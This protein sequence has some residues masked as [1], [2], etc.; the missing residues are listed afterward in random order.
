MLPTTTTLSFSAVGQYTLSMID[1]VPGGAYSSAALAARVAEAVDEEEHGRPKL[2][3]WDSSI[4]YCCDMVES[5][6]IPL[7]DPEYS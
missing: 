7:T 4:L 6:P 1:D 2:R 5:P 3:G